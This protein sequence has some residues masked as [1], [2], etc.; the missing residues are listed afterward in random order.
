M[1]VGVAHSTRARIV[2]V[3]VDVEPAHAHELSAATGSAAPRPVDRTCSCPPAKHRAA[4]DSAD[5]LT[6]AGC[7][8][9]VKVGGQRPHRLD[10]QFHR[11]SER[12]R[13]RMPNANGP[14]PPASASPPSAAIRA[15]RASRQPRRGSIA[16]ADRC[17]DTGP[18][19]G[20]AT[21]TV[22]GATQCATRTRGATHDDAISSRPPCGPVRPCLRA[23]PPAGARTGRRQ[24]GGLPCPGATPTGEEYLREPAPGA[25]SVRRKVDGPG[26]GA[27]VRC[28]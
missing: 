12:A 14:A 4:N 5:V 8:E 26:A 6:L 11:A 28:F 16:R 22:P 9:H 17:D 25:W 20:E 3:R 18:T 13:L 1:H 23:P 2:A 10:E 19:L 7:H 15:R 27:R 21:G 24:R